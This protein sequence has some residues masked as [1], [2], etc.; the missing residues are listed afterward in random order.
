MSESLQSHGLQQA[1]LC[2]T[3][4][5]SLLKFMSVESVLNIRGSLTEAFWSAPHLLSTW[6]H[7]CVSPTP[8]NIL[9]PCDP[10]RR[11]PAGKAWGKFAVHQSW[12]PWLG[13]S[14]GQGVIGWE[15][16]IAHSCLPPLALQ[17]I[18]GAPSNK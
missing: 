16:S 14:W 2:F 13:H 1:S 3:I 4:S 8:V 6:G 15:S 18:P 5:W 12:G 10:R 9:S 17:G 7:L 11:E